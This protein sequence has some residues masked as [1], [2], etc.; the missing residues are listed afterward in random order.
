VPAAAAGEQKAAAEPKTGQAED[1]NG[2]KAW[3]KRFQVQH[4]KIAKA[5]RELD[6]LQRE[7]EKA[8][9]QYYSDPQK[10][11]TQQNSR[12]DILEKKTKIDAKKKE[13]QQLKQELEDLEDQLRKSGGDTGWAR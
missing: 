12:S 8:Q 13:I 11:L 7:S 6:I 3:R 2:E 10:A 9:T 1:P 5:E 4:D